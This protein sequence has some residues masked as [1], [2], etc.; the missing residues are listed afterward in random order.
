LVA[1]GGEADAGSAIP[2]PLRSDAIL[3][4]DVYRTFGQTQIFNADISSARRQDA[5]VVT[6][7]PRALR[8]GRTLEAL[9]DLL[10]FYNAH[11]DGAGDKHKAAA[12]DYLGGPN[13]ADGTPN[14]ATDVGAQLSKLVSDLSN[15][16][17]ALKIGAAG[18]DGSPHGLPSS[19]V[20]FQLDVLLSYVNEHLNL[21]TGA[22]PAGAIAYTGTVPAD[23][24][25]TA[26]EVLNATKAALGANTF[27]AAQTIQGSLTVSSGISVS[28]AGTAE[29]G[30]FAIDVTGAIR[31]RGAVDMKAD[32]PDLLAAITVPKAWASFLSPAPNQAGNASC[33]Y[34]F[35][36][37]THN[38]YYLRCSFRH[39]M[40]DLN[41]GVWVGACGM[42]FYGFTVAK[43]VSY[44][45]LGFQDIGSPAVSDMN[46]PGNAG[47]EFF[48]LVLGTHA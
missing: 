9:S 43:A 20:K 17:G 13:W 24:V 31:C 33:G 21:Q 46:S 14:P 26:I 12:I 41:Y 7:S 34:N 42:S 45:D 27:S 29:S 15:G 23:R 6:G 5:L 11:M 1:Q 16:N 3:L 28:A 2:P 8:R 25:L 22:H 30:A 39:A 38:G 47:L 37:I 19:T 35:T 10:A 4:A 40:A 32:I 36:S 48:V 18:T 44:V